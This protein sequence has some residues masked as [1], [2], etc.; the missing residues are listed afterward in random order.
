MSSRPFGRSAS[1]VLLV[2]FLLVG[3]RSEDPPPASSTAP[4][5]AAATDVPPTDAPTATVPTEPAGATSLLAPLSKPGEVY[6]AP[7][8]VEIALDGD[9]NDWTNVPRV[10]IPEGAGEVQGAAAVTFAAAAGDEFIYLMADVTD[11]AI[12]SGEHGQDYWNEDSVEFYI[13]ASGDLNLTSYK[14]GVAQINIPPLNAGRPLEEIVLGGVQG[15][16]RRRAG[17][18]GAA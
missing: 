6:Y 11:P 9:L 17:A 1:L 14:E 4:A 15:A 10:T 12:I 8:P 16:S 7:F 18:G 2:L 5:A 13:N 3:C